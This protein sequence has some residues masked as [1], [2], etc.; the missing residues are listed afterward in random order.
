MRATVTYSVQVVEEPPVEYAPNTVYAIQ[1]PENDTP[2]FVGFDCPCGC[3]SPYVLQIRGMVQGDDRGWRFSVDDGVP[4]LTPSI[5]RVGSCAAHFFLR[6][7]KVEF[8]GDSGR[9]R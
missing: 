1:F 8:C 5:R 7:G 6:R 2:T 9:R 4:T 3:G